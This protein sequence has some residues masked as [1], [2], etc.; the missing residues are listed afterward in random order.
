MATAYDVMIYG[1]VKELLAD[2][3]TVDEACERLQREVDEA[4]DEIAYGDEDDDL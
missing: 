3:L 1:F 4:C 2:G